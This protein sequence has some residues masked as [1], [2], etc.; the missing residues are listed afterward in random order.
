MFRKDGL[1]EIRLLDSTAPNEV[2]GSR[3]AETHRSDQFRDSQE[4]LH[5]WMRFL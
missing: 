5:K 3:A 4:Q 2:H 1:A